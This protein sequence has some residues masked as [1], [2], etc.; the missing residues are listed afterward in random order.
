MPWDPAMAIHEM[1]PGAVLPN[2]PMPDQ[3]TG[4]LTDL[5]EKCRRPGGYFADLRALRDR[6][7]VLSSLD[8]APGHRMTFKGR[9]VVQWA[10]NNY[11]GLAERPEMIEAAREAAGRWGV[12]APMGSRFMTGNSDRH[13]LL[14]ARLARFFGTGDAVLFNFGYLGVLGTV[15]ALVGRED[16]VVIDRLC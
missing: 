4:R 13:E 8:D 6:Y 12:S 10:I 5:F 14:E 2:D 7:F 9:P 11:L 15:G 3:R 16:V 1:E